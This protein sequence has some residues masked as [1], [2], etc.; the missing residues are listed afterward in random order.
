MGQAELARRLAKKRVIPNDDRS[1]VNKM[2]IGRDV[3]AEEVFA[4]SEIT[5]FAAPNAVTD[6]LTE[7]PLVAWVSAGE[8]RDL[9]AD[10]AL[11]TLKFVGLPPGDWIALK[12]EG[13]SMDRISPPDSII[14]VNRSDR[15]LVPNACYVIDDGEGNSS[16][17]RYRSNPSRYEPVS[18]NKDL[19]AIFP[20]SEPT[21]VGRVRRTILDL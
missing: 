16:Y 17:K 9:T 15:R 11:L 4:I 7:V 19:S 8:L 5:G 21:I 12:V 13:D 10:E 14:L 2:T 1:I 6:A 3:T 18:T 20:E